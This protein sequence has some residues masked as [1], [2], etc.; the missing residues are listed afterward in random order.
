M[1]TEWQSA[2][3]EQVLKDTTV[4]IIHNKYH[5]NTEKLYGFWVLHLWVGLQCLFKIYDMYNVS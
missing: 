3:I 5:A 2:W 1:H 4:I